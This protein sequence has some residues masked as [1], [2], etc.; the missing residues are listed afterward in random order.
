[1]LRRAVTRTDFWFE[2]LPDWEEKTEEGD[3]EI[4]GYPAT[5]LLPE[6]IKNYFQSDF[7]AFV[8]SKYKDE[9][10]QP[11]VDETVEFLVALELYFSDLELKDKYTKYNAR[12]NEIERQIQG[13]GKSDFLD[14]INSDMAEGG[15]LSNFQTHLVNTLLN[16]LEHNTTVR[17]LFEQSAKRKSGTWATI[18]YEGQSGVDK[19]YLSGKAPEA[20]LAES[21]RMKADTTVMRKSVSYL[22]FNWVGLADPEKNKISGVSWYPT[23]E[24]TTPD[25]SL[26][27]NSS[28]STGQG[29]NEKYSVFYRPMNEL[30]LK[31]D[32]GEK[33]A[34]KTTIVCDLEK[35]LP[36]T[37][38]DAE[39]IAT[40]NQLLSDGKIKDYSGSLEKMSLAITYPDISGSDVLE[41]KEIWEISK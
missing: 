30:N 8:L 7:Y 23:A 6:D 12:L 18:A 16:E 20:G 26:T 41:I 5:C 39:L 38:E 40:I 34:K 4:S 35:A 13:E 9:L 19:Y 25:F 21:L 2:K 1:M 27:P 10:S 15:V 31:T 32:W 17:S 36:F 11:V 14:Q 37:V 29:V 22:A 28:I 33:S 3:T 24:A